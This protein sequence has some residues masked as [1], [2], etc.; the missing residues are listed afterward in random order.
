MKTQKIKSHLKAGKKITGLQALRLYGCYRLSA[1]IYNLRK[2]GMNIK[3]KIVGK[4]KYA[5]YFI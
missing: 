4:E 5:Q 2:S 1:V 3:T